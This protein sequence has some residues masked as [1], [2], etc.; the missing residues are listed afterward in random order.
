M[1][2][3]E[4]DQ[5]C[6]GLAELQRRNRGEEVEVSSGAPWKRAERQ[7]AGALGG[8]RN[9]RRGDFS[10]SLPVK[11]GESEWQTLNE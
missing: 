1:T 3:W 5:L 7:A 10:Q 11:I 8:K 9:Q 4:F 6:R 2:P